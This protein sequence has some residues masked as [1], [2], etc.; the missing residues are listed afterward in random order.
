MP[1]PG[2]PAKNDSP[3]YPD[4]VDFDHQLAGSA[5][6]ALNAAIRQLREHT[7]TD[8][9]NG[10]A[11]LEQWTG[12]HGE[13]FATTDFPW[14]KHESSRLM[15]EMQRMVRVINRASTEATQ[16]LRLYQQSNEAWRQSH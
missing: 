2:E 1:P 13:R 5:V 15:L 12:P 9:A 14:I 16:Q 11:A 4:H 7:T 10:G 3:P 8:V 6:E